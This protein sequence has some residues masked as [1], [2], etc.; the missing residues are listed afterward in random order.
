MA[1]NP[2]GGPPP[3]DDE[4]RWSPGL[5]ASGRDA[6][7]LRRAGGRGGDTP[8]CHHQCPGLSRRARAGRGGKGAGRR[9]CLSAGRGAGSPVRV[10]EGFSEGSW[11]KEARTPSRRPWPATP[12][13]H[14]TG[15]AALGLLCSLVSW[16]PHVGRGKGRWGSKGFRNARVG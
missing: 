12:P 9:S 2:R 16:L 6:C 8:S 10:R 4:A 5:C 11:G 14:S 3:S 15:L 7:P 13:L 1:P